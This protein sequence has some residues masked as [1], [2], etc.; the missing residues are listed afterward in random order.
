MPKKSK[1]PALNSFLFREYG[2]QLVTDYESK[3]ELADI[4]EE[5]CNDEDDEESDD[6][7]E[8]DD[9]EDTEEFKREQQVQFENLME[10]LRIDGVSPELIYQFISF[11]VRQSSCCQSSRYDGK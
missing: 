5:K 1:T 10:K 9:R 8:E 3:S 7:D 11:L 6:N 2:I 4:M